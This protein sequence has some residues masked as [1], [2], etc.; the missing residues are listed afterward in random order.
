MGTKRIAYYIKHNAQ[1]IIHSD[2][3]PNTALHFF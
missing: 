3:L 1:Y 2:I